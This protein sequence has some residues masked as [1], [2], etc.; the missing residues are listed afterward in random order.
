MDKGRLLDS[1]KEISAYLGRGVRTC[2]RWERDLGLPVHRLDGS[3]KA[4]VFAYASELDDWRARKQSSGGAK[5]GSSHRPGPMAGRKKLFVPALAVGTVLFAALALMTFLPRKTPAPPAK[6][7]N[8]IAVISF[9][10]QTGDK[11]YDYLC[12]RAIPDLLITNLENAGYLYIAT[13]ERMTDLLKQMG[14]RDLRFIDSDLGFELC[15]REGISYLVSGSLTKAGETFVLDIKLLDAEKKKLLKAH[16]TRGSGEDSILSTQ[17]DELS[18]DI[19]GS[20]GI[21]EQK[22]EAVRL[23]IGDVTT[24][25]LEAYSSYLEGEDFFF[26][27]KFPEARASF[28]KALRIDPS[29][30]SAYRSLASVYTHLK[31][32]KARAEA[33]AKAKQFSG[34]ATRKEKLYIEAQAALYQGD[35]KAYIHG[36][37]DIVNKYPK[38]KEAH[39]MLG[40]YIS[41]N[42]PKGMK[43]L[44]RA[45]KEFERVLELDPEF[46]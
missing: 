28:E 17:I 2:R 38:D 34:T 24:S 4:R 8:S 10:N 19:L 45:T 7:E 29:F 12:Q 32:Y 44:A 43:D 18:R 39:A 20:V 5:E 21:P 31:D 42:A 27:F 15:R 25:S 1:W 36:L 30:A 9:R 33:F 16:Q 37:E 23:V 13:W 46:R 26:K 35:V 22:I 11:T 14:K 6:I 40:T 3:T 41:Y